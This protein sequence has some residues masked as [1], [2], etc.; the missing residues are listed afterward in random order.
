MAQFL[1]G[2]SGWNY[3]DWRGVFYPK[4]L[5]QNKWL[6]YYSSIFKAIEIN[7][8]FYRFFKESTY[9]NWRDQVPKNFHF[10]LKAHRTIT[11]NHRLK[12]CENLITR[13][14]DLAE[15]FEKKLGLILLQLVPN[16]TYDIEVLKSALLA[17]PEPEKIAIEFRNQVWFTSEVKKLLTE[18]GSVFCC[19]DSP[20][21]QLKNWVT[22]DI[23]YIRL[24][25]RK[26][27]YDYNYTKKELEEIAVLAKQ[28]GE[29]AK[30]VYIF[31]NNDYY[32]YAVK[33]ALKLCEMLN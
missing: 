22:S 17:F 28:M 9:E 11:H 32:A 14:S 2:T 6:E 33:N 26:K 19:A 12:N 7:A 30:K 3:A 31:F 8:T 27:W 25:G 5:Q 15:I 16:M 21:I 23:A 4:D 20:A 13:F 24:H 1:I 10:V 18:I 29:K